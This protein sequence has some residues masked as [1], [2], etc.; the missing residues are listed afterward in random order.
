MKIAIV[1]AKSIK[2]CEGYEE[3][4]AQKC[5]EFM[6]VD[7]PTYN[8]LLKNEW[9]LKYVVIRA[10]EDLPDFVAKSV[11]DYVKQ[12]EKE[13]KEKEQRRIKREQDKGAAK[14]KKKEKEKTDK[15]ELY[16]QLK[17]EFGG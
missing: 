11:Q 8:M 2:D 9:H 12:L 13:E 16:E 15:K 6:D 17:K 7:E 5:T 10:V 3:I 4:I 1:Q 14:K